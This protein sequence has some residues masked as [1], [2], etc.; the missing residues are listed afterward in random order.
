MARLTAE[1]GGAHS[2]AHVNQA[3]PS[4][5]GD[6]EDE[7]DRE[8][9]LQAEDRPMPRRPHGEEDPVEDVRGQLRNVSSEPRLQQALNK[10]EDISKVGEGEFSLPPSVRKEVHKL[11]RNLGHPAN[12]VFVRA[13]R[14]AKVRED[15]IAWIKAHF[16]RPIC[17]ARPRATPARPGHLLRALEFNQVVGLDLFFCEVEGE[18]LTFVNCLC[19]GTNFQQVALSPSKTA[20][21]V[22]KTF[23]NEWIKHYGPPVLLV[24]DQGAEFIGKDF[25]NT[26]CSVGVAIH[27]TDSQSPWQNGRTEKAGGVWKE[28]FQAVMSA[29]AATKEEVPIV[30]AEVVSSRNRFM[31]RYGFSPMQRVFGRSLRLPAS[32]MSSDAYDRE[33]EELAANDAIRRQRSSSTISPCF[34]QA[35]RFEALE[36]W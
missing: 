8:M 1:S 25:Q 3:W 31:D 23:C 15:V 19:W 33:L 32:L 13:L 21:D 35:I 5:S 28:K 4:V 36:D 29:T 27:F 34:T 14:H 16:V 12:E 24:C 6:L 30:I 9:A 10:L 26:I 22:K 17:S 20:E 11:H 2:A 7:L 18:L